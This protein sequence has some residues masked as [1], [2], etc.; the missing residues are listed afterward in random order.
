VAAGTPTRES[1]EP[2]CTFVFE[3]PEG[4]IQPCRV[5]LTATGVLVRVRFD[6]A[7]KRPRAA[8]E[9]MLDRLAELPTFAARQDEI[10]AADF[11]KRPGLPI[12]EYGDE[13]LQV[14]T[15]AL[16]VLLDHPPE[17]GDIAMSLP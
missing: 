7:R 14:L 2:A 1:S 3:A 13:G 6:L 11:R 8:L 4:V 5:V 10:L 15:Q 12:T 17:G 16:E 9:A